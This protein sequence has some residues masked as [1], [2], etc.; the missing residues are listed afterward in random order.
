MSLIIHAGATTRG[1]V[2]LA[3]DCGHTAMVEVSTIWAHRLRSGMPLQ[4]AR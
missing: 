2:C 3:K 1:K 4:A